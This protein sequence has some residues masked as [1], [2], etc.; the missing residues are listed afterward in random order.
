MY[1]FR[2]RHR[3]TRR[4]SRGGVGRYT[5]NTLAQACSRLVKY[6]STSKVE[7]VSGKASAIALMSNRPVVVRSMF[8]IGSL[9]MI[10]WF[11]S[12]TIKYDS[13]P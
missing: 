1:P 4:R 5:R 9:S 7:A 3:G 8:D 11:G 13:H 2:R 12:G 10:P 6:S